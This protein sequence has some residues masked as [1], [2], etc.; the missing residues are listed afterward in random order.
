MAR[1]YEIR[2]FRDEDLNSY[3][4]GLN[5]TLYDR[6]DEERFQWKFLESP[7]RLGFIPIAVVVDEMS[8]KPVGFNSFLPLEVMAKGE[9]FLVVQGCDA[10]VDR[11]HRRRGLFQR[12]INF[13]AEE[14]VGRGPE[15]LIGFNFTGST[16]ATQK[17]D[18]SVTCDVDRWHLD[19]NE[20]C[21]TEFVGRRNMELSPISVEKACEIYEDWSIMG[22]PIHFHRTLE[23]L[24]WRFV[25]S[26][27]RN[28]HI[29]GVEVDGIA[30]GYVVASSA[31]DEEGVLEL[32][33]EDC[34]PP[35]SEGLPFPVI[36]KG[37][38]EQEEGIGRVEMHT[39]RGA[40]IWESV[41]E[42]GFT[43]ELEPRYSVI[44]KAIDGVEKRRDGI[45]R[46][47][48]ELTWIEGWHLTK[49]DMF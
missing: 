19:V 23:Y 15:V 45:Y 47:D 16:E 40:P 5:K 41:K 42:I 43:V 6:Y 14:L 8:G 3:I 24:K 34:I 48:V 27:L 17:V 9:V 39:L 4:S 49:S 11:E 35:F 36:L 21:V 33:I 7:F 38:L 13:M 18:S 28:Y 10:F 25:D 30:V 22:S 46:G 2:W 20:L 31:E 1:G 37:I 32:S 26:P 44:M 12:T 29:Y